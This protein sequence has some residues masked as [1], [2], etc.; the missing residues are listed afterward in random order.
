MATGPGLYDHYAQ[1]IVQNEQPEIVCVV[2]VGGKLGNGVSV[3]CAGETVADAYSK[4]RQLSKL[5]VAIAE[6]MK[7][8]Y[9]GDL[10]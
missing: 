5:L 4:H 8:D 2:I 10:D 9:G 1:V 7:R 6:S 3:K